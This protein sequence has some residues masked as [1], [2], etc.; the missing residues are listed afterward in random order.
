MD[1][2]KDWKNHCG[3]EEKK[4]NE[5]SYFDSIQANS[6]DIKT[7]YYNQHVFKSVLQMVALIH[8]FIID[9]III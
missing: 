9:I 4:K 5:I 1:I 3:Q 2:N 6:E 8:I 7:R